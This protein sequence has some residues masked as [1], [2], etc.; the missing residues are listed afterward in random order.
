MGVRAFPPPPSCNLTR[1]WVHNQ[2]CQVLS[3][4]VKPMFAEG[5]P[6]MRG[7]T[8]LFHLPKPLIFRMLHPTLNVFT[9]WHL[10]SHIMSSP[11]GLYPTHNVVFTGRWVIVF[12]KTLMCNVCQFDKPSCL[13]GRKLY[14]TLSHPSLVMMPGDAL[15]SGLL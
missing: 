9:G 2:I 8:W 15:A 1:F 3:K 7:W 5:L 13:H 12:C 11:V 14:H 4:W 6:I 10:P